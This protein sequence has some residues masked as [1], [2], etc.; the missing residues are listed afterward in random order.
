MPY[1][2]LRVVVVKKHSLRLRLRPFLAFRYMPIYCGEALLSYRQT[3][4]EE[5]YPLSAVCDYLFNI[6]TSTRR[7]R[8]ARPGGQRPT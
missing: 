8:T 7:S 4:K 1:P 3:H 5:D 6:L 2:T